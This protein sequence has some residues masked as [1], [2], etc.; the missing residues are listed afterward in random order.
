MV[1]LRVALLQ[2][3]TTPGDL[4]G[5]AGRIIEGTAFP[6]FPNPCRLFQRTLVRP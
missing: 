5:N 2:I 1:P 6:L 4:S 3:D